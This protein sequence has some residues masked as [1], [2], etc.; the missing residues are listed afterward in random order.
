MEFP[1]WVARYT[2]GRRKQLQREFDTGHWKVADEAASG[3]KSFIK[4]EAGKPTDPRNISPRPD[5][6]LVRLGPIIA[7]IERDFKCPWAVKHLSV[8]QRD[9]HVA[10]Y[11]GLTPVSTVIDIDQ[12][13]FDRHISRFWLYV[14][15]ELLSYMCHPDDRQELRALLN[16]QIVTRGFHTQGIRYSTV[17]GRCSG[18]ANTSIGNTILNCLITQL[19][20]CSLGYTDFKSVHDGDDGLITIYGPIMRVENNHALE[21]L[22]EDLT[23]AMRVLG[24]DAKIKIHHDIHTATF[25]GRMLYFD[26][27]EV[28]SMADPLRTIVK[29]HMTAHPTQEKDWTVKLRNSLLLAKAL[30]Y[31]A[32]DLDTPII[33]AWCQFVIRNLT[34]NV[35]HPLSKSNKKML[36]PRYPKEIKR[37]MDLA[38]IP[39]GYL[40]ALRKRNTTIEARA[41]FFV[42]SNIGTIEQEM[43]EVWLDGSNN[44]DHIPP[45]LTIAPREFDLNDLYYFFSSTH[46]YHTL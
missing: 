38:P 6:Y 25:D 8:S 35:S 16:K 18:D 14:E 26:R 28:K 17:G 13:R 36:T 2:G 46:E 30:S 34:H 1:T 24:F 39:K 31:A 20:F 9:V 32:S 23:E 21:S 42:N 37:R 33:G 15:T 4:I 11:L 7:G 22:V 27:G 45:K 29:M 43:M 40:W 44:I 5:E 10:E 3:V 41:A 12:S 19:A